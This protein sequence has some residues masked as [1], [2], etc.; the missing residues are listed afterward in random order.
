MEKCGSANLEVES[1]KRPPS[2]AHLIKIRIT[3]KKKLYY[4]MMGNNNIIVLLRLFCIIQDF[5]GGVLQCV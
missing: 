1:G 3:Y 2:R 4:T 5:V